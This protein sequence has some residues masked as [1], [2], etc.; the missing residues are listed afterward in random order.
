MKKIL[1]VGLHDG[2]RALFERVDDLHGYVLEEPAIHRQHPEAYADFAPDRLLLADYQQSDGFV[3]Q[4]LHWHADVHF[5][6]VV[7][8]W[9]YGVE[10]AGRLAARLGLPCPGARALDACT[11]KIVL[12]S[13]VAGAV[14]QPRWAEVVD[15]AQVAAFHRGTPVVVKPS[16]RRASVGVVR[17]DRPEDVESAWQ[18]CVHADESRAVS[19]RPRQARYLVEEF[20]GGYQVSVEV[21]VSRGVPVFDNVC[22][23]ETAGGPYFPVL[24]VTVPAPI[25]EVEY[26]AAVE[27]AHRLVAA[28]DA[29]DGMIHS[30]WKIVDGVPYL[31]ESAARVPGAFTPELAARAYDGF[32]MYEAQVRTLAGMRPADRPTAA[33]VASV[34]WLDPP[35]GVVR[36]VHGLDR[37]AAEPSVFLQK[38]KV[39]AGD[40]IA[41]YTDS[42]KRVGYFAAE[43]RSWAELQSI[44]TCMRDL[45]RVE[46]QPVP[47]RA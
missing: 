24:A 40:T 32:D 5:D 35:A 45:V 3:A 31:V 8:A 37:L 17:V 43:A 47:T 10:A 4:A 9:E 20:L 19:D 34:R 16:N 21:L 27:A 39:S 38:V 22:Y 29:E 33:A 2:Y 18:H 23:M 46:V 44:M 6:A 11:D 14:A 12:R 13:L 41:P 25:P 7:P 42:W 15:A 26:Q 36:A 1:M 30:E 28:L